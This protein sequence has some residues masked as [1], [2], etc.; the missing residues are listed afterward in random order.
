VRTRLVQQHDRG[1][2]VSQRPGRG[3]ARRLP[4]AKPVCVLAAGGLGYEDPTLVE[5]DLDIEDE[6]WLR[7]FN[8]DQASAQ[9]RRG[10]QAGWGGE[11]HSAR[12]VRASLP[13]RW[14]PIPCARAVTP[15]P[16]PPRPS[17]APSSRLAA[18]PPPPHHTHTRHRVQNRLAED[19]LEMMLWKLDLANAQ[20][21]DRVFAFAG[22]AA[23]RVVFTQTPSPRWPC[24]WRLGPRWPC[25]RQPGPRWPYPRRLGPRRCP[26][27]LLHRPST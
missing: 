18:R 5:Y 3:A 20:A 10:S 9:G 12:S 2:R 14:H 19:R 13:A 17:R 21:T 27:P 6:A 24:R 16:A 4:R 26:Q 25:P 23:A 7:D 11:V 8:G 1:Q 22:A 15:R